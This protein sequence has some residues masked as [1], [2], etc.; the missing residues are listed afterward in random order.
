MYGR[1]M[2]CGSGRRPSRWKPQPESRRATTSVKRW[3]QAPARP[4]APWASFTESAL[5]SAILL[6]AGRCAHHHVGDLSARHDDHPLDGR[7]AADKLHDALVGKCGLADCRLVGSGGHADPA[8]QLA[9]D[10][11]DELDRIL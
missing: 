3:I 6:P 7:P 1:R 9:V 5:V 10:L 2:G 4:S 11:H 8:A